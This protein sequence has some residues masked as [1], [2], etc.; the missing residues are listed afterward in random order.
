MADEKA[1][2]VIFQAVNYHGK[3]SATPPFRNT[4]A[5]GRYYGYFENEHKEQF[6]FEYDYQTKTGN[7]WAGDYSWDK[8]VRVIE[9]DAPELILST[10]ERIWLQACWQAATAFQEK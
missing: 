4:A 8:P 9:G 1:Q 7:L 5:P 10:I 3:S 2:Q 6:I